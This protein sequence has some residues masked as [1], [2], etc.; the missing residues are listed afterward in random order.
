MPT[1]FAKYMEEIEA[2]ALAE[3]PEAVR[4]LEAMRA[5]YR[6]ARESF[7]AARCKDRNTNMMMIGRWE[8]HA[9]KEMLDD[10]TTIDA[11]TWRRTNMAG[12]EILRVF[13][14]DIAGV[15]VWMVS[16][17]VEQKPGEK[18]G[19]LPDGAEGF[20]KTLEEAKADADAALRQFF[21]S[22]ATCDT[23]RGI[24][25][26]GGPLRDGTYEDAVCPETPCEPSGSV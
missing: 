5:H 7:E 3:G 22:H 24:G 19:V 2:E 17:A 4:Q 16:A 26:V 9:E 23:C 12:A 14:D 21:G 11:S 10:G 15:W 18:F 13:H 1:S 25:L 6:A 8:E 20:A